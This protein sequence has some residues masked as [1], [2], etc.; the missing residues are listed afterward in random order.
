MGTACLQPVWCG[1]A[2]VGEQQEQDPLP[3]Y[4]K[5]MAI[6]IS[7]HRQRT[8]QLV[9]SFKDYYQTLGVEKSADAKAIKKAYY[10]LAKKYHPDS[11]DG[12]S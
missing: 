9:Q 11:T 8:D 2:R 6:T 12:L 5:G 3:P 10:D 1:L 4:S 7:T